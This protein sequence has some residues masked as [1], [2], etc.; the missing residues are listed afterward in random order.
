MNKTILNLAIYQTNKMVQ[1]HDVPLSG[2]DR[3]CGAIYY[4]FASLTDIAQTVT[5]VACAT[6]ISVVAGLFLFRSDALNAAAEYTW[7]DVGFSLKM[8]RESFKGIANPVQAWK[9]K[10]ELHLNHTNQLFLNQDK[11][12]QMSIMENIGARLCF[13]GKFVEQLVTILLSSIRCGIAVC[14]QALDIS[15][16]SLWGCFGAVA[17]AELSF[18]GAATFWAGI[19]NPKDILS[20]IASPEPTKEIAPSNLSF[21]A[22]YLLLP[23]TLL[24]LIYS[25]R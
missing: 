24:T 4:V 20:I 14:L 18:V 7:K 3:T 15:K 1:S 13:L 23:L 21:Y 9:T 17:S 11:I 2:T 10:A 25:L 6:F 19:F 22:K 12:D 16:A 8:T 5:K